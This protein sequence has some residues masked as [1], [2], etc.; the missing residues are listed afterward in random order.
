MCTKIRKTDEKTVLFRN[1]LSFSSYL[2]LTMTDRGQIQGKKDVQLAASVARLVYIEFDFPY[3]SRHYLRKPLCM[4]RLVAAVRAATQVSIIVVVCITL[5][6]PFRH[7]GSRLTAVTYTSINMK[8]LVILKLSIF[9]AFTK[10]FFSFVILNCNL[11][12]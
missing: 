11:C 8:H 6:F 12:L 10:T 5:P 9:L 3:L 4:N 2:F 1:Y 7:K